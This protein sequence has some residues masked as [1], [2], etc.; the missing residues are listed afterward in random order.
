MCIRDS[1]NAAAGVESISAADDERVGAETNPMRVATR[2]KELK[3]HEHDVEPATDDDLRKH[4]GCP[5]PCRLLYSVKHAGG[6]GAKL[7]ARGSDRNA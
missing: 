5:T 6:T 3:A 7:S 4:K 1:N 2:L